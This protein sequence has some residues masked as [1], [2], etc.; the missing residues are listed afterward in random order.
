M[1]EARSLRIWRIILWCIDYFCFCFKYLRLGVEE[2]NNPEM[3]TDTDALKI[4][5]KSLFH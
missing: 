3:T 2:V 1:G 5:M 4:S